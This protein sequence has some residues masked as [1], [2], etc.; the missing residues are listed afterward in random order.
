MISSVFQTSLRRK[1][2]HIVLSSNSDVK[3]YL[4]SLF[5]FL[6]HRNPLSTNPK[7]LI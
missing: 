2:F 7:L 3:S 6:F 5:S 4:T 1:C